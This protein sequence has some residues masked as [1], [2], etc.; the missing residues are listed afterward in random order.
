MVRRSLPPYPI[1]TVLRFGR[2]LAA[3]SIAVHL[4]A[5]L[6]ETGTLELW[7]L[8]RD[9]DHRW[10]L[11]FDLRGRERAQ[12]PSAPAEDEAATDSRNLSLERGR[13]GGVAGA[14]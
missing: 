14:H 5:I 1:S 11:N 4:R 3:R 7:C 13:V 6:T 12:E 8:S 10:R 2:S 9:T